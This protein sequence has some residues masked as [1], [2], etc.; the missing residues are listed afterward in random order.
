VEYTVPFS[1]AE[2]E[3][4]FETWRVFAVGMLSSDHAFPTLVNSKKRE[5][6]AIWENILFRASQIPVFI[7]PPHGPI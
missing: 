4:T 5:N 7:F 1:V 2:E 6:K 3:V